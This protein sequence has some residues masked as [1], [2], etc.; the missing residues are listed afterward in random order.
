[1]L[2]ARAHTPTQSDNDEDDVEDLLDQTIIPKI[3]RPATPPASATTIPVT[4]KQKQ[5]A[6]T[7]PPPRPHKPRME[8]LGLSPD[9]HVPGGMSNELR[10]SRQDPVLNP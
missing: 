5:P 6:P 8:A 7:S 9:L 10:R 1:M 3:E 4:P 2:P